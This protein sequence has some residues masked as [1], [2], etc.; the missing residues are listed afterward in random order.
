[1]AGFVTVTSFE[2]RIRLAAKIVFKSHK[3]SMSLSAGAILKD[4]FRTDF[5]LATFEIALTACVKVVVVPLA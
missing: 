3:A 5:K 2:R 4:S 1:M